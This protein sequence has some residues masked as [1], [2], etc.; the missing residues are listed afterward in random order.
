M[1]ILLLALLILFLFTFQSALPKGV[2][3]PDPVSTQFKIDKLKEIT[4]SPL[5]L[6]NVTGPINGF[7]SSIDGFLSKQQPNNFLLNLHSLVRK[8]GKSDAPVVNS[9]VLYVGMKVGWPDLLLICQLRSK[10][11]QTHCCSTT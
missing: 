11:Q 2:Q 9:L 1:L 10:A 6:S 3:L 8:D 4:Q 5:I 7:K